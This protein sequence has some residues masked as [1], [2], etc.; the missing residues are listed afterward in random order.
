M[1]KVILLSVLSV[2][3]CSA[4]GHSGGGDAA[5]RVARTMQIARE[6]ITARA[7]AEAA[8]AA[9]PV[10]A[11]KVARARKVWEG[12]N[13]TMMGAP[14]DQPWVD[15]D[16][17]AEECD[18]AWEKWKQLEAQLEDA[19]AQKSPRAPAASGEAPADE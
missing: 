9:A 15:M 6:R 2:L 1:K 13:A 16:R 18:A 17:L 14:Y 7:V 19:T 12:W 3:L 5:A 11:Q 10:T 4:T 8:E